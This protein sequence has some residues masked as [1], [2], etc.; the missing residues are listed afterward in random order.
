MK[1]NLASEDARPLVSSRAEDSLLRTQYRLM[2]SPSERDEIYRLRYRAY[3]REGAI[4]ANATGIVKDE[5]D[6]VPNSW[7][8]GVYYDGILASSLRI[9]VSSAQFPDTP[10]TAV[11]PDLLDDHLRARRVM[12]DPTRFVADPDDGRRIPQLPYL[13][14]RLAYMATEHFK[15]DFGLAT[16][17]TEHLPFYKRTFKHTQLSDARDYP[18][19][20]KPICLM[21][22]DC[23]SNQDAVIA[24][25]PIFGSSAAERAKLFAPRQVI[26]SE[27]R[28]FS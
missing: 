15:A 14:V 2:E 10:S 27:P 21:M 24:R 26:S 25:Y 19:L 9:S 12:V 18:G 3:L 20:T 7:I 22:S 6:E 8:F 11:F 1:N 16:V 28:R 17:R 4:E 13:T 23:G 5:Y